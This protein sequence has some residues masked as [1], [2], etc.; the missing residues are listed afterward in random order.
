NLRPIGPMRVVRGRTHNATVFEIQDASGV[1]HR[2][3]LDFTEMVTAAHPQWVSLHGQRNWNDASLQAFWHLSASQAGVV[4]LSDASGRQTGSLQRNAKTQLHEVTAQI[5]LTRLDAGR[6]RITQK[7][8][9]AQAMREITGDYLQLRDELLATALN[10]TKTE[11]GATIQLCRLDGEPVLLEVPVIQATGPGVTTLA[12]PV[13]TVGF[14]LFALIA[15]L[16]VASVIVVGVFWVLRSAFK[17]GRGGCALAVIILLGLLLVLTALMLTFWFG[18]RQVQRV[19]S[20][21]KPAANAVQKAPSSQT[22]AGTPE[23][24]AV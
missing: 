8:G 19:A 21:V 7:T 3:S 14:P 12:V 13:R 18:S 22:L 16:G 20:E 10:S 11:R 1:T 24:L 9:G 2:A 17:S 23:C 6:L 15:G 5:E 4:R